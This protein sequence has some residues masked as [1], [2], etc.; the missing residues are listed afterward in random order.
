M[1]RNPSRR[2]MRRLWLLAAPAQAFA[3]TSPQGCAR[4]DARRRLQT[5]TLDSAQPL[6]QTSSTSEH[7]GP[8]SHGCSTR[9]EPNLQSLARDEQ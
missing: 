7:H 5:P 6:G 2:G 1:R 8:A 3:I 4:D 9:G